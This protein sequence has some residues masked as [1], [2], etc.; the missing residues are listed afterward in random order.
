[1]CVRAR[2]VR[3]VYDAAIEANFAPGRRGVE[4]RYNSGHCSLAVYIFLTCTRRNGDA[5]RNCG[6]ET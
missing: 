2:S 4:I 3:L 6:P 5:W 1:M